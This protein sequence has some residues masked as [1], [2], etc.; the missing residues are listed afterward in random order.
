M[1]F[2]DIPQFPRAHYQVDVSWDYLEDHIAHHTNTECS[3]L[4]L[5]P[6]VQRAHVWNQK[7]QVAYVEY[8]LR[9][10]EVGRNLTFNCPGWMQDWRGPYVI[11]DG[12]QRLQAARAFM[13]DEFPAFGLKF[14]EYSGRL[15]ITGP[16]FSWRVCSLESRRELLEF[17]L[18]INTGGTPHT[19]AEL[20]KVRAMLVNSVPLPKPSK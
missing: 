4:D 19:K 11:V 6:D 15:H 1:R 10:G 2:Q 14:S 9:G 5:E 18:S 13:R 3:P 12:K 8:I 17:Y 20:D 16:S 7:Q